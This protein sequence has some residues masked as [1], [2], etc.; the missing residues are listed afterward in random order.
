MI[1]NKRESG[2]LYET[3]ALGFLEAK[4]FHLLERNYYTKGGE[5]DLILKDGDIYSTLTKTKKLRIKRTI[6]KWLYQN[7]KVDTP[8]RFD[9]VGI[10]SSKNLVEHFEFVSL[11][12]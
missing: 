8:W 5:I 11:E 6:S 3:K 4:G 2:N 12:S 9:Y 10:V 7:N 1:F